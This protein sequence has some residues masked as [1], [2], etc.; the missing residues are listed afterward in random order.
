MKKVTIEKFRNPLAIIGIFAGIAEVSMTVTLIQ[1]PSENQSIFL[2]FVMLFP[3]TLIGAFFFVLYTR[4][5]VLFSPSDYQE[6]TTYLQSIGNTKDTDKLILRVNQLEETTKALRSYIDTILNALVEDIPLDQSNSTINIEKKHLESI[7]L[8]HK[9]E[10][11]NLYSFLSRELKISHED[12]LLIIQQSN[13]GY[14][15]EEVVLKITDD[16]KK[17]ARIKGLLENF[18]NILSD[19]DSLKIMINLGGA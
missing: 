6:D 1:L 11:N 7:D 9:F 10:R 2:W 19:F 12:I 13:S 4:P 16:S 15:L 18:P 14:D 8:I 5:T 17:K 3:F